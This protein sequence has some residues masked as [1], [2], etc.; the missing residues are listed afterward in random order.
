MESGRDHRPGGGGHRRGFPGPPPEGL[1]IGEGQRRGARGRPPRDPIGRSFEEQYS[2]EPAGT[3]VTAEAL[4][5]RGARP[6]HRSPTDF[7]LNPKVARRLPEVMRAVAEHGTVDWAT[8]ELLAFGTLLDEGTPVRLS[9]QDSARGTFSQRH[10]VWQDMNTQE[11]LRPPEPH[12]ARGRPS[13]ACTTP[14]SRRRR[15]W[16][17]TTATP[18]PSPA[19]SSSGRPSSGT[20]PT[21]PRSSSTSSS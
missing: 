6:H 3:G 2:H 19:C 4:R 12:P 10:S 16:A 13:S 5:E 20:S 11:P 8:A 15:S 1:R 14:C 21:A 18:W 7:A 9:G 17:S